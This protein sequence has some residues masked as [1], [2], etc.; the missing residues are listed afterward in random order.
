MD[1]IDILKQEWQKHCRVIKS[2][3][4]HFLDGVPITDI[5]LK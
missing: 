3:N 5:M 2:E 1:K 4:L